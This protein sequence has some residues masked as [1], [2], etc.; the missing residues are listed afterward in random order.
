MSSRIS[1]EVQQPVADLAIQKFRDLFDDKSHAKLKSHFIEMTNNIY[2]NEKESKSKDSKMSNAAKNRWGTLAASMRSLNLIEFKIAMHR[3]QNCGL[4][5]DEIRRIFIFLDVSGNGRV[6][7]D[8][9]VTAIRVRLVY[10][11]Y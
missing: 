5:F 9:F 3:F 11:C 8:E 10:F 1:K 4:S 2:Q 6:E 7:F